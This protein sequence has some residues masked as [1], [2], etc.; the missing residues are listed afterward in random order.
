MGL[1]QRIAVTAV[2]VA[3]V[4][5]A[6]WKATE[7]VGEGQ[8]AALG[9][10]AIVATVAVTLGAVW[11]SRARGSDKSDGGS[12]AGV[13]R[14]PSGQAIGQAHGAV[15]GP[16]SNF[17]GATVTIG[18]D[19]IGPATT[20][21][22]HDRQP[23]A[24]RALDALESG[25]I[26]YPKTSPR[27]AYR[28]FAA[29]DQLD[30]AK[31]LIHLRG[32]D[33]MAFAY[34]CA[35]QHDHDIAY[36]RELGNKAPGKAAY[37]LTSIIE[38]GHRRAGYRAKQELDRLPLAAARTGRAESRKREEQRRARQESLAAVRS[39]I[40]SLRRAWENRLPRNTELL[41]HNP[42][43]LD[44]ALSHSEELDDEE[45]ALLLAI[46]VYNRNFEVAMK[47]LN[48]SA[49]LAIARMLVDLAVGDMPGPAWRAACMLSTMGDEIVA[50]AASALPVAVPAENRQLLQAACEHRVKAF[51]SAGRGPGIE[52][53]ERSRRIERDLKELLS[54]DQD[55][56]PTKELVA[57]LLIGP[58]RL[59]PC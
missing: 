56:H 6:G 2:V 18:A 15:F 43:L 14:S 11:V 51:F 29:P 45:L 17:R 1:W 10:A 34:A 22:D 50:A 44:E 24:I 23:R 21:A 38:S 20:E 31:D 3:A 49:S 25:A 9:V 36:W 8:A 19:S 26:A 47:I 5:A 42:E 7:A 4:T 12:G 30:S 27:Y 58:V 59:Q 37:Y 57:L 33:L 28:N 13:S 54:I 53:G 40:T 41:A 39:R 52:D 46:A 48:E 35:V 16:R 32:K 55:E